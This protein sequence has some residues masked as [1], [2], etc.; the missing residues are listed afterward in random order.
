VD[1]E[2]FDSPKHEL[3]TWREIIASDG[4]AF[5]KDILRKHKEYLKGQVLI[6]VATRKWDVAADSESRMSECGKVLQLVE[7][8]LTELRNLTKEE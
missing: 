2:E 4:W 6:A 3:S 5:F 7:D 8:R 1:R